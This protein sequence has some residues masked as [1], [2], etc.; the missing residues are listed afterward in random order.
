MTYIY[1]NR[2]VWHDAGPDTRFQLKEFLMQE[3]NRAWA[4][5]DPDGQIACS[6]DED[7]LNINISSGGKPTAS[8]VYKIMK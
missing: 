6:W 1:E 4:E 5:N 2:S 8:T 3:V 7:S